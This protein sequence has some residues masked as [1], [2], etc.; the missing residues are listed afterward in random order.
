MVN[1]Y[2]IISV[3]KKKLH[4]KKYYTNLNIYHTVSL[5]FPQVHDIFL[6]QV[7]IIC[8]CVTNHLL[9]INSL[10]CDHSIDTDKITL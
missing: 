10:Y 7:Q 8:Y 3:R 5:P 6:H 2:Y 1:G 4:S 9:F